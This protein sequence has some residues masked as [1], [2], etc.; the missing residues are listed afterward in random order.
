MRSRQ[1]SGEGSPRSSASPEP[2]LEV[3]GEGRREGGAEGKKET[4]KEEGKEPPP[5]GMSP[6]F[7]W[8]L[9]KVM[10]CVQKVDVHID[11]FIPQYTRAAGVFAYPTH[12]PS[13]H[14]PDVKKRNFRHL[15]SH[16]YM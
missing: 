7:S 1:Y 4:P 2:L 12:M 3:K 6:N 11:Q 16:S 15:F 5:V 14:G 8:N 9:L 13:L 10:H